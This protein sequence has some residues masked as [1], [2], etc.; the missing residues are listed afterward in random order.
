MPT[1]PLEPGSFAAQSTISAPSRLSCR[2]T[3]LHLPVEAPVPR[4]SATTSM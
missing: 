3:G 4:T 1:L 2:D